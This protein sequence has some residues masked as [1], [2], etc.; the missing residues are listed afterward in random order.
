MRERRHN[1]S[2][3]GFCPRL[4][5]AAPDVGH[6][7]AQMVYDATGNRRL[8][9][10]SGMVSKR[11]YGLTVDGR[12]C[13]SLPSSQKRNPVEPGVMV[14]VFEVL[15]MEILL[16]LPFSGPDSIPTTC[17]ASRHS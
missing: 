3:G 11:I 17:P 12:K 16:K 10:T 8:I 9:G 7:R 5:S 13:L 6:A 14:F 1:T 2:G 15:L 4:V